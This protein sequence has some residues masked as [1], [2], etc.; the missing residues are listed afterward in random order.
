MDEI[1]GYDKQLP[2]YFI[3]ALYY[4]HDTVLPLVR[5][6]LLFTQKQPPE[7]LYKKPILKKLLSWRSA[8]LLKRD[9]NIPPNIA[10]FLRTSILKNI[11]E[12]LRLFIFIYT[13]LC[14]V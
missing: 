11:C 14:I 12:R 2:Y 7:V 10:K 13:V 8:T 6:E 1:V 4:I 3:Y 9:S 5:L